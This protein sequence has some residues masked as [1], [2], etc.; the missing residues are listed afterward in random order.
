MLALV[1]ALFLTAHDHRLQFPLHNKNLPLQPLRKRS[2]R[3]LKVSTPPAVATA[4][5]AAESEDDSEDDEVLQRD[6]AAEIQQES[7]L[8]N[9]EAMNGAICTEP[10]GKW[11]SRL[12]RS[13]ELAIPQWRVWGSE[14]HWYRYVGSLPSPF[15]LFHGKTMK[16]WALTFNESSVLAIQQERS[17]Q[18]I[19]LCYSVGTCST[20][21]QIRTDS[22]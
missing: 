5:M 11:Q 21:G 4:A 1:H 20:G 19:H 10:A 18:W 13:G 7:L 9:Q 2:S 3:Y 12:C 14:A 17:R 15:F 22:D 6:I 8:Q 16:H